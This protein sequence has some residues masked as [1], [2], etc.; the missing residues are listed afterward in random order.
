MEDYADEAGTSVIQSNELRRYWQFFRPVVSTRH[1]DARIITNTTYTN[2]DKGVPIYWVG[3][4]Q[5]R[6]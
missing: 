6:G 3:G 1:I 5:G 4:G 2:E